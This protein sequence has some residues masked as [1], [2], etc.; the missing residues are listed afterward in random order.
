MAN[1]TQ[2][3]AQK[4]APKRV[5]FAY[6]RGARHVIAMPDP[7]K[8]PTDPVRIIEFE[9]GFYETENQDEINMLRNHVCNRDSKKFTDFRA[10]HE[11]DDEEYAVFKSIRKG[12]KFKPREYLEQTGYVIGTRERMQTE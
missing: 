10:F 8:K 9:N 4:Q 12:G 1:E 11:M 6:N 7:N 5:C 2:N 3:Q